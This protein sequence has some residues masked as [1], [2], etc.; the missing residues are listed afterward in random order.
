[1]ARKLLTVEHPFYIEGRGVGL[2]PV[3]VPVEGELFRNGDPID[4]R[5]PDGKTV[6]TEIAALML[7]TPNPHHGVDILLPPSFKKGDVPVGAE[8]WSVDS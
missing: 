8:V 6:R 4:I 2:E 1:M 5:F 7:P 3:L